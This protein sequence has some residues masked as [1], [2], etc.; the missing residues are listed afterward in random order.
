MDPSAKDA[1]G[2]SHHL[3]QNAFAKSDRNNW[4]DY[5]SASE[6]NSQITEWKSNGVSNIILYECSQFQLLLGCLNILC[7]LDRWRLTYLWHQLV[8]WDI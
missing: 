1:G 4:M 8:V 5:C 7:L 3:L 6:Y 2:E